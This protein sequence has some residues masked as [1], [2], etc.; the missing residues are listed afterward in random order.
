MG[1]TDEDVEQIYINV[2]R[3]HLGW[4][5]DAP[6][7]VEG[8]DSEDMGRTHGVGMG[9][10]VSQIARPPEDEHE[11][12]DSLHGAVLTKDESK[13]E[14]WLNNGTTDIDAKDEYVSGIAMPH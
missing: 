3:T 9:V 8:D 11:S 6:H 1:K 5:E 4:T 13:V 10:S 2:V 7:P 12:E 14:S